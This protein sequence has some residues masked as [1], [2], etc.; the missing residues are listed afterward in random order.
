MSYLR[1][2][3]ATVEHSYAQRVPG[4]Q[5]PATVAL[6]RAGV[7]F[8]VHEYSHVAGTTRYGEEAVAALGVAA[9]RVFK[10]LVVRVDER[11]AVGIVP[12][13]AT[14][15]LKALAAAVGGKRAALA[16]PAEAARATGYV[17]GGISPVAQRRRLP[18]A[19]DR[20]AAD[21]DTVYVSA[22]R[23]GLQVELAPADLLRVTGG[24]LAAI[25]GH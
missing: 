21:C 13:S 24:V 3:P 6:R 5:T 23:R 2:Q 14:L 18:T 8:T 16:E 25:A 11:L 15:D 20:S 1:K 12:V 10:T 17:I 9:A 19:L 4:Q 7:T 22:G